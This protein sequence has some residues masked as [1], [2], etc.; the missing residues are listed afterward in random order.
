MRRSVAY[1]FKEIANDHPDLIAGLARDRLVG[2]DKNRQK[3]ICHAYISP[4]KQGHSGALEVF[5]FYTPEIS[6]TSIELATDAA[7]RLYFHTQKAGAL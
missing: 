6:E 1:Y 2:E 7:N 5:G 3:L 4:L